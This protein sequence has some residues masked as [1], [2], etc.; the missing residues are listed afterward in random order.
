ML[1]Y[2]FWHRPAEG[3]ERETYERSAE[4]FHRSLAHAPPAGF[5]GSA[6]YR[7]QEPPWLP[8]ASAASGTADGAVYED[9]YFVEDFTALGVLNEAAVAHGHR[10]VHDEI[11]HRYGSGAG[12]LYALREGHVHG[13]TDQAI[14]IA[15]PRGTHQ[16]ELAELLGDGM[17]PARSS[18]WRRA[19]V[20]GPAP[21]YCLLAP[22]PPAGVAVTRLPEGWTATACAREALWRG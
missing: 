20:L 22:E 18:L 14:W 3:V 4:H 12:G 19:L 7:M 8:G 10:G 6:L 9:W 13:A 16:P 11:A 17:D 21:E 1:A 5:C 2:L 15:R